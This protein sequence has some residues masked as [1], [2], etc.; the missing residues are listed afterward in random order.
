[1]QIYMPFWF[2]YTLLSTHFYTY[3]TFIPSPVYTT[4]YMPLRLFLFCGSCN[5]SYFIGYTAL[6]AFVLGPFTG[7][8]SLYGIQFSSILP[9][10][11]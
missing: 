4:R 11:L 6:Y 5:S 2:R 10:P 7:T 1:M 9:V 8:Y 3:H